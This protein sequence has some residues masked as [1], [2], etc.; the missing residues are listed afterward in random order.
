MGKKGAN[1]F[2]TSLSA[3]LLAKLDV[4]S[5]AAE[6]NRPDLILNELTTLVDGFSHKPA[7]RIGENSTR[8]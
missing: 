3:T 8:A 4:M 2:G 6:E 7:M 1:S 5:S